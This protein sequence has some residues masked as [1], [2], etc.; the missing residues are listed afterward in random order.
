MNKKRLFFTAII[1]VFIS[2]NAYLFITAPEPLQLNSGREPYVYSVNDGFS[3]L[4]KLNDK[5]RGIYTKRIV[6]DG[7]TVQLKFDER[8]QNQHV[9]AG[10]LPA[11]FLRSTSANLEKSP[12]PLGLYLGSDYPISE[13]NLLTGVQGEK[14]EEI[15]QDHEPRFFYDQDTQRYIA[16]FPDFASAPACVSC[17]NEHPST[18]KTDWKLNDIM[19]ATTWSFPRDSLTSRELISWVTAYNE[20]AK[21]SYASY[22]EKTKAFIDAEQPEIGSKWPSEG[23]FLPNVETFSEAVLKEASF[24]LLAGMIKPEDAQ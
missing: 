21:A 23:Y 20:S 7:K 15:K 9:E 4:A 10:P 19:G 5:Y 13:S 16:M 11:L 12:I 8:W 18:P 6:G 1:L 17:H 24:S 3:L 22:L 14:F 2:I